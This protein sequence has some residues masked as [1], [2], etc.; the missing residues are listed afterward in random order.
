MRYTLGCY[1]RSVIIISCSNNLGTAL[2]ITYFPN[3]W[4]CCHVSLL[5]VT[6]ILYLFDLLGQIHSWHLIS[7]LLIVSLCVTVL[8]LALWPARLCGLLCS[9]VESGLQAWWTRGEAW[10]DP[11]PLFFFLR[12]LLFSSCRLS[13]KLS[14]V[15]VFVYL[16]LHCARALIHIT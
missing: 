11:H 7:Q 3:A 1:S 5:S 8:S 4:I 13:F 15:K 6:A 10:M 2:F 14:F 12:V 16:H 9:V